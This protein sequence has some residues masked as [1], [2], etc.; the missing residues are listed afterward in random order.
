MTAELVEKHQQHINSFLDEKLS[1]IKVLVD[2]YTYDQL[3]D[4]T[5]LRR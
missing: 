4:E 3:T 2:S 1:C 5:F